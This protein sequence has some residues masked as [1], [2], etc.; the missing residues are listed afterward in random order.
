MGNKSQDRNLT[1][2]IELIIIIIIIIIA[3]YYYY[4]WKMDGFSFD[5]RTKARMSSPL[6]FD[7]LTETLVMQEGK[8]KC[9]SNEW[10][11]I[12]SPFYFAI[13]FYFAELLYYTF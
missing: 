1:A 4:C 8:K 11:S 13:Q 3:Y 5:T 2:A 10:L 7:T 6:Q 12:H 9:V